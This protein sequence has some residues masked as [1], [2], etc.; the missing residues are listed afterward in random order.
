MSRSVASCI[1]YIL[2][3]RPTFAF[4]LKFFKLILLYL[5]VNKIFSVVVQVK[6]LTFKS[7]LV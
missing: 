4:F 1:M 5:G 3:G 2:K 7:V 6:E